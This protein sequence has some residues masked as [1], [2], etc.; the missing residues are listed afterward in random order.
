[1]YRFTSVFEML[2]VISFGAV[3]P[4]FVANSPSV[5]WRIATICSSAG[6]FILMHNVLVIRTANGRLRFQQGRCRAVRIDALFCVFLISNRRH[7]QEH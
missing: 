7:I 5:A 4:Y 6:I 1:M 3:I 2:Q